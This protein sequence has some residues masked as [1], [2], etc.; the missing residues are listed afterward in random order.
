MNVWIDGQKPTQRI[1]DW[2]DDVAVRES[3]IEA[4]YAD[5]LARQGEQVERQVRIGGVGIAD[6]VTE[7]A[8]IEVKL[9]LTRAALFSAVGQ[10]TTYAAV[11]GKERRVVFGYDA[12][13]PDGLIEAI[14]S[15]GVEVVSWIGMGGP[16]WTDYTQLDDGDVDAEDGDDSDD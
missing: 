9:W 14:R 7:D 4:A 13:A 1:G 15:A 8:V 6:I 3:E 16:G 11:L 10:V 2:S 5:Q 12:G